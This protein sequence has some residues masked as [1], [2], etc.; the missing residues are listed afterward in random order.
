MLSRRAMMLTARLMLGAL[1]TGYAAPSGASTQS[2]TVKTP[3]APGA[4]CVLTSPTLGTRTVVT[5]ATLVVTQAWNSIVV[6]C[7][8]EC[9]EDS[10]AMIA[11]ALFGGYDRE[12]K[13]KMKPIRGCKPKT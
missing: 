5:P 3:N 12:T 6:R 11:S 13:V 4:T 7:S 8:K 1:I 2:I 10:T 9:F